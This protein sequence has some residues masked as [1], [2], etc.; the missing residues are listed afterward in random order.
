MR[1][2]KPSRERLERGA[3][4]AVVVGLHGLVLLL[5]AR[6]AAP[7]FPDRSTD[8][9]A[10]EVALDR[11]RPATRP[12]ARSEAATVVPHRPAL[13]APSTME[14][15]P[16]ASGPPATPSTPP[17]ATPSPR[18]DLGAVLRAGGF[19]CGSERETRLSPKERAR[20]QDKL[21]ALALKA[22][23]LAAPIDPAK[24]AYYDAVAEAYRNR[25]QSVPLNARGGNG[26]FDVDDSV[27]PG[28]GPRIGCSVK[29]G[30]NA[31]RT[32]KGPPNALRAGPCFIQPP[33]GSL[34]PEVDIRKPY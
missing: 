34:T 29:F 2:P 19:G 22:E 26:M 32:P 18:G 3:I 7:H 15:L 28:H 6:P 21:G 13:P 24:R 11:A 4:L 10:I 31:A 14:T 33:N 30:P 25:G 20:C 17:A 1:L 12:A 16:V 9:G 23:P 8:E 5:L 27:F